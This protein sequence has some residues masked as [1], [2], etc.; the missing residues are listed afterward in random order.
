MN[1][2]IFQKGIA[3]LVVTIPDR[4]FPEENLKIWYQLLR[5]IPGKDFLEA[6]QRICQE[7]TQIYPGTN[8]VALIRAKAQDKNQLTAEEAWAELRKAITDYGSYS[9]PKFSSPVIAKAVEALGWKEICLSDIDNSWIRE[10]FFR[11]YNALREREKFKE[12][13][14]LIEEPA[15]KELPEKAIDLTEKLKTKFSE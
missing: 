12:L 3:L 8:L 2:K 10:H 4:F 13:P 1:K 11:I 5:D 15:G 7:E 14:K 6:V 9:N